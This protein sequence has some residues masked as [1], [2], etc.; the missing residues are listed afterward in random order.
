MAFQPK[1]SSQDGHKRNNQSR[2]Q[3]PGLQPRQMNRRMGRSM[4]RFGSRPRN[5][6]ASGLDKAVQA[7]MEK[8]FQ[9]DFSEVKVTKDS[10]EASE[11][12]AQAFTQGDKIHFAPGNYKP[13][14]TEGQELI[15]HELAHVIQQKQGRVKANTQSKGAPVNDDPV[16]EQEADIMGRKAAAGE[17][18]SKNKSQKTYSK[19]TSKALQAQTDQELLYQ[20]APQQAIYEFAAHHLAYKDEGAELNESEKDFL[21]SNGYAREVTYFGLSTGGTYGFQA[22][23]IKS[24]SDKNDI[25]AIRGTIP[26]VSSENLFT[27][28]VD[29]DPA[30]VGKEQFDSNRHLIE[31]ILNSANGKADI[32]GHSLGGAMAQHIAVNFPGQIAN[33]STFQS[34][35]IDNASVETFNEIPQE[36]RPE[37]VHHI[38]SGDLIDKA[39]ESSLPGEVF[40]HNFGW[41]L[42]IAKVLNNLSS[43]ISIIESSILS[44]SRLTTEILA[45]L[46]FT[47]A[48]SL[49][50]GSQM[51]DI[52]RKTQEL[53][54]HKDNMEAALSR[55]RQQLRGTASDVGNIG[56]AHGAFAFSSSYYEPMRN[57][58]N[59]PDEH[60][61]GQIEMNRNSTITAHSEYP[62]QDQRAIA[63]PIRQSIGSKIQGVFRAVIYARQGYELTME[64]LIAFKNGVRHG[65]DTVQGFVRDTFNSAVNKI[66]DIWPF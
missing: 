32:T 14:S 20:I 22:V 62:H 10:E 2:P 18:A 31:E 30:A 13:H 50:P 6:L 39:G 7:K 60:L 33:V 28:Y 9:E 25:I 24:I 5:T 58:L 27:L 8:S 61:G 17:V 53:Q 57:E 46:A 23:L 19:S 41:N 15:G 66:K 36:E 43:E 56:K 52:T 29:L 44:M 59:Y 34:P 26:G 35:G 63:E 38:I 4:D 55:F 54:A 65:V 51:N 45:I 40:E 64:K 47:P 11:M 42:D 48:R 1:D 37:V 3:T 12:G 16:I 49:M 21:F